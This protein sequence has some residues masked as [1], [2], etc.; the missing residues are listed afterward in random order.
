MSRGGPGAPPAS[1]AACLL[2]FNANQ[3]PQLGRSPRAE[4]RCWDPSWWGWFEAKWE[5]VGIWGSLSL[6][7]LSQWV[8]ADGPG[9]LACGSEQGESSGNGSMALRGAAQPKCAAIPRECAMVAMGWLYPASKP[10]WGAETGW[11]LTP[12]HRCGLCVGIG[13]A[14]PMSHNVHRADPVCHT[15]AGHSEGMELPFTL[16]LGPGTPCSLHPSS[17]QRLWRI[18]SPIPAPGS[19]SATSLFLGTLKLGIVCNGLCWDEPLGN[20]SRTAA[21]PLQRRLCQSFHWK[22]P[23][24]RNSLIGRCLKPAVGSVPQA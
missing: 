1:A 16:M 3:I 5:V 20:A 4:S 18:P 21:A 15:G 17:L 7:G 11:G 14:Y 22:P 10:C 24:V 23:F 2:W 8:P 19:N 12:A 6:W 13:N 9:E